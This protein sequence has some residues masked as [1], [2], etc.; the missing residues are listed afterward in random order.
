MKLYII[1]LVLIGMGG[2]VS[3]QGI[4]NSRLSNLLGHPIQ[5]SFVSFCVGSLILFVLNLIFRVPLPS[6]QTIVRIPLNL[7]IGG[8]LGVIYVTSA[9]LFIPI[10]GTTTFLSAVIA[11]QLIMSLF[12]D[13]YGILNNP[14]HNINFLRVLG[15]FCL[16]LGVYLIKKS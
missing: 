8:A 15:V 9:I 7:W 3:F 10:V 13:H 12:I 14:I 2:L 4:I 1:V 11:G 6:F 5:A 16:L